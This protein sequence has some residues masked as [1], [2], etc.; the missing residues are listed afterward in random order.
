MSVTASSR[1]AMPI[2]SSVEA[3]EPPRIRITWSA[4]SRSGT[5]DVVDLSPLVN[6]LRFYRP[7]RG[8]AALFET[9]H[10]SHE[11]NAIAWRGAEEL[12]MSATSIERLVKEALAD[13]NAVA[14]AR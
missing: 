8:D 4:G 3:L 5:T 14:G 2:I 13:R 7:L 12:D 10:V 9:V 6:V 1:P 11:G